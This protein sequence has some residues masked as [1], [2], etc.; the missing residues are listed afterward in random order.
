MLKLN[1]IKKFKS[2]IIIYSII[3]SVIA[4]RFFKS[5]SLPFKF[6]VSSSV[7]ITFD[8]VNCNFFTIFEGVLFFFDEVKITSPLGDKSV[9]SLNNFFLDDW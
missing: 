6:N 5:S 9:I 1:Q 7:A 2:L 3:K 4:H 8:G